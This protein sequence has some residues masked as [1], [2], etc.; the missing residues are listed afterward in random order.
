MQVVD[1]DLKGAAQRSS[2]AGSVASRWNSVAIVPRQCTS[3]LGQSYGTHGRSS[4]HQ[5]VVI[6][7]PDAPDSVR[8]LML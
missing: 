1:G 4:Q 8:G 5:A 2:P 3:R 7:D 6:T